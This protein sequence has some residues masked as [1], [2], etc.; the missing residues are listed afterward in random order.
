[1]Q[2]ADAYDIFLASIS[3]KSGKHQ[4]ASLPI[5]SIHP[6]SSAH[7]INAFGHREV[8]KIWRR[9]QKCEKLPSI[10]IICWFVSL[11]CPDALT[12]DFLQ[13]QFLEWMPGT[14]PNLNSLLF[15]VSL[16]VYLFVCLFA[17]LYLFICLFVCLF[18]FLLVQP[19]SY[20]QSIC[21][22]CLFVSV[23]V[24]TTDFLLEQFLEWIPGRNPNINSLLCHSNNIISSLLQGLTL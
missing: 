13:K 12:T 17:Y 10:R 7:H 23:F 11:R 22:F 6:P 2:R 8:V 5:T 21:F 24:C 16:T 3:F 18:V 9:G 19:I 4:V 20:Y 15:F 14:N 1:M